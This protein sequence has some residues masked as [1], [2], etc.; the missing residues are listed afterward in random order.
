MSDLAP[1][2]STFSRDEVL[3]A[4]GPE[5]EEYPNK[6]HDV[7]KAFDPTH[8]F[9]EAEIISFEMKNRCFFLLR[10]LSL[11][12]KGHRSISAHDLR[13]TSSQAWPPPLIRAAENPDPEVLGTLLSI[14]HGD[15]SEG[16]DC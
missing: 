1:V 3:D 9:T 13:G 10:T 5:S 14:K 8:R 16:F 15:P 2:L 7:L 12:R 11:R 4:L 6:D